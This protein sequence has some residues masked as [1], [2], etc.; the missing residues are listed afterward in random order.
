[1]I[2]NRM[3]TCIHVRSHGRETAPEKT[4]VAVE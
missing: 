4:L 1:M 2:D 3:I